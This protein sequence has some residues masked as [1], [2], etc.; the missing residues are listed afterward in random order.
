MRSITLMVCMLLLAATTFAQTDNRKKIEV[1]GRADMEVVPDIIYLQIVLKEYKTGSKTISL[2]TLEEGL[3]KAINQLGIPK[4]NLTVDNIYGYNWEWR[5]KK[6]D[7]FLASKSFKLKLSD[8]K[9]I[10][11]LIEKLDAE[12]IN[13]M[14]VGEVSHTKIDEYRMQL[15]I[16][17]LK[18][19]KT[20]ARALLASIDEEIGVALDIQEMNYDNQPMY[21][22][23]TMTMEY[24]MQ[25]DYMSEV[26]FKNITISAE[27]RAV[28]EIK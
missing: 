20:K 16:E 19:A 5:K 14:N 3:V 22:R 4:E 15:K 28:F 6:V 25:G 1:S 8:V 12:G 18:I 9:L 10:N 7:D 11:N 24:K 26:E 27:V 23:N 17:A 13:S 2:N 21:A